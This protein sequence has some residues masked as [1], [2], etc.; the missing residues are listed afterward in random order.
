[1]IEQ[2][3]QCG[4]CE[5]L[6]P[7]AAFNRLR[8]GRQHWCRDCFREYFRARGERHL[9]QSGAARDRR[10]ARAR[11]FVRAHLERHPCVDCEERDV[12]VLDFDHVGDKRACVSELAAWGAPDGRLAAEIAN[13]ELRCCNSHRRVTYARRAEAA[14]QQLVSAARP[15]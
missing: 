5:R 1:V 6:L 13:C 10:V 12:R 2:L 11:A 15:P 7:L 9:R 14:G 8:D 3:K 4:R